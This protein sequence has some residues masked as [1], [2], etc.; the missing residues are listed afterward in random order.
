MTK[1]LISFISLFLILFPTLSMSSDMTQIANQFHN[2]A[3]GEWIAKVSN[4]C[5][6]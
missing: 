4:N 1:R 6:F 2:V 3:T 5:T